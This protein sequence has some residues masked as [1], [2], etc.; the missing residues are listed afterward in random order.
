[1]IYRAIRNTDDSCATDRFSDFKVKMI[2]PTAQN[3]FHMKI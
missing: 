1:L 2:D 3:D